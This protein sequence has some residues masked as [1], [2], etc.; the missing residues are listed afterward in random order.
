MPIVYASKDAEFSDDERRSSVFNGDFFVY[1]PRPSTVALRDYARDVIEQML[2]VEPSWAQQRMSETEFSVLF[3]V[4]L[5]NF[6]RSHLVLELVSALVS[7]LGC[8]PSATYISRPE[9]TAITGQGFLAHGLNGRR[10]PHRDTWFAASPSQLNWWTSLYDMDA[11]S[12]VAFH[13]RYWDWPVLNSSVDFEYQQRPETEPRPSDLGVSPLGQPRP[14]E[15]VVLSPELRIAAPAGGLVVF[16]SA[17]LHSIVPNDSLQTSFAVHFQTVNEIDLLAGVGA[18]NLDAEPRG[19]SLSDF[20]RCDDL[21]AIS[22]EIM[23]RAQ[24]QL[25]RPDF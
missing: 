3:N 14:L 22:A 25:T 23:G 9:L 6:S 17:Q 7:D 19:S 4:A 10:H 21:S 1:H 11:T 15:T 2:G 16:S 20:V 12:S 13:P 8:D 18:A 5:R 24:R